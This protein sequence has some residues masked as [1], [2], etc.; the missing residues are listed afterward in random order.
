MTT[1][2]AIFGKTPGLSPIK[3]RLAAG[4]GTAKAL[5]FYGLCIEAVRTTVRGLEAAAFCA[6]A[7]EAAVDNPIWRGS[8]VLYTGEGDLG[9]R[10]HHIY[11][12]LLADHDRV[13]LI[14]VDTPQLSPSRLEEAVAALHRNDFVVGPARD[15]GYYLFGGRVTLD[16]SVWTSVPWSTSTTLERLEAGL[17]SAPCR[18]PMLTD[19]DRVGDL[20]HVLSEMPGVLHE[21]QKRVV[22][23]IVKNAPPPEEGGLA[24]ADGRG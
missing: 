11:T 4:I 3:T 13:L 6:V 24:R 20:R 18:L 2:I 8:S 12:T 17:P 21:R 10:Q 23:W 5:E 16:R 7:E 22:E 14:G 15:G 1:A 19:V 9:A